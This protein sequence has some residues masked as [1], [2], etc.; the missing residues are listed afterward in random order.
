VPRARRK[1]ARSRATTAASSTDATRNSFARIAAAALALLLIAA[2]VAEASVLR[3][4][5][6]SQLRFNAELI[7][8]GKVV[9]VRSERVDGTIE[10]RTT[11]RVRRAHKGEFVRELE[12]V[13]P[14]GKVGRRQ[15]L[16]PGAAAMEKGDRVLLF[17]YS[18]DSAWRAVGM[19]QG[20]WH[21]ER[22]GGTVR[23]SD[24]RGASLLAPSEGRPAVEAGTHSIE[25]LLGDGG[26]R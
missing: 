10:T 2:P 15:W 11:I 5:T 19:F 17:L 24:P 12:V 26:V 9:K 25:D 14:G 4:L 21:L 18:D 8:E 20:V 23:S 16:V 3:G 22:G 1:F 13:R 6:A 7:V